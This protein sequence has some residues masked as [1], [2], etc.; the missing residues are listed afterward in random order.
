MT[1]GVTDEKKWIPM[2]ECVENGIY[3]V[4]ARNFSIGIWMP[5]AHLKT[6]T[7]YFSGIRHKWG[8]VFIDQEEHWDCGEPHGTAKPYKLLEM[9]GGPANEDYIMNHLKHMEIKH[10]KAVR[11]ML[12]G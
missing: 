12:N 4:D 1:D 3:L 2:A 8:S 7:F 5:S 11:R 10:R 6:R 9:Y